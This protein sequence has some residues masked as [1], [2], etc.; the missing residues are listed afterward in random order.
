MDIPRAVKVLNAQLGLNIPNNAKKTHPPETIIEL[1][2]GFD[3]IN[4]RY[5]D[6]R[7][8]QARRSEAIKD[9]A[10]DLFIRLGSALWPDIDESAEVPSW[11][12]PPSGDLGKQYLSRRYYSN[13]IDR[14]L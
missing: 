10:S 14:E 11:L 6:H 3:V 5:S 4:Q 1:L 2:K 9:A 12:R 13:D 8:A 7:P